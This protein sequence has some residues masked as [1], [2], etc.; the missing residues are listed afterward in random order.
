MKILFDSRDHKTTIPIPTGGGHQHVLLWWEDQNDW[1]IYFVDNNTSQAF[2][3]KIINKL[4]K[5]TNELFHSFNLEVL[6][7][8]EFI[9]YTTWIDNN[10]NFQG[11][12]KDEKLD[13]IPE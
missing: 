3:H 12:H 4:K 5:D 10:Y 7:E 2:I 9:T 13:D 6:S 8:E 1:Y 11:L